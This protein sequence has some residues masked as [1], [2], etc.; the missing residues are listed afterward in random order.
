[1]CKGVG[2]IE[3]FM[4]HA[5][6]FKTVDIWQADALAELAGAYPAQPLLFDHQLVGHPLLGRDM[7]AAAAAEL[8]ATHV[9]WRK[10][11][12]AKAFVPTAP[13]AAMLKSIFAGAVPGTSWL[14]LR[15]LEDSPDYRALIDE[16]LAPIAKLSKDK[17]GA[18]HQPR[19]FLFLST[20]SALTPFH[21]DPEHNILFHLEGAKSFHLY[22]SEPPFLQDEDQFRLHGT[23]DN[24][25][26]LPEHGEAAG[27]AY[28]LKP[29]QALYVPYK[30]PHWVKVGDAPSLSL[31][32][33]WTSD[34]SLSRDAAWRG[35]ALLRRL[36]V[37]TLAMPDWPQRA[38]VRSTLGKLSG[39]LR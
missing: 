32:I 28:S 39:L 8:P 27:T 18:L 33:T 30:R 10:A 31:S 7:L 16:I 1:M 19:A 23:G 38:P 17:T 15:G 24:L 35:E 34:W 29:G 37:P 21:F 2:S 14:M 20:A 5:Q 12:D 3:A 11:S 6:N 36:H 13:D 25:L 9:E 4:L 26:S 22:P